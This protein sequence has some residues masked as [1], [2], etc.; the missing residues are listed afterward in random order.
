MVSFQDGSC[1]SVASAIRQCVCLLASQVLGGT[2]TSLG[3]KPISS[4]FIEDSMHL[5]K[6]V[7]KEVKYHQR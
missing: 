3:Y 7:I 1:D 2:L 5:Y 6:L 4:Y